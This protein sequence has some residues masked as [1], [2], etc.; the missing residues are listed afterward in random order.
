MLPSSLV[1]V[2]EGVAAA[3]R[4]PSCSWMS[5]EM[6]RWPVLQLLTPGEVEGGDL[7]GGELRPG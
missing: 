1:L 7:E 5:C 6:Q 2:E 3:R 4:R